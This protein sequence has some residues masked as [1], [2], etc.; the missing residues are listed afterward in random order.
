MPDEL[1]WLRYVAWGAGG[2]GACCLA[3]LYPTPLREL[4]A[5]IIR[6]FVHPADVVDQSLASAW[7][8]ARSWVTTFSARVL[9]Q[10]EGNTFTNAIHGIIFTAVTLSLWATDLFIIGATIAVIG[11]GSSQVDL[12]AESNWII[13][14][15]ILMTGIFW[16]SILTTC[17]GI[18]PFGP[19]ARFA[20]KPFWRNPLV[21]LA[22]VCLALTAAIPMILGDLRVDLLNE[23]SKLQAQQSVAT[24]AASNQMP[25][26]TTDLSG[27]VRILSNLIPAL[28]L[29]TVVISLIGFKM[30]FGYLGLLLLNLVVLMLAPLRLCSWII[31]IFGNVIYG[32]LYR[33]LDLLIEIGN[34]ILRLFGR[35]GPYV[36]AQ[37][38]Q[39]QIAGGTPGGQ[40]GP[41]AHP[42][43]G[44]PAPESGQ[45]SS[46]TGQPAQPQSSSLATNSSEAQSSVWAEERAAASRANPG[47]ATTEVPQGS[48]ER[49]FTPFAVANGYQHTANVTE[50]GSTLESSISQQNARPGEI[51][52][53]TAGQINESTASMGQAA[54]TKDSATNR[55]A[56][57]QSHES[58]AQVE[59]SVPEAGFNPFSARR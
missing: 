37:N 58:P 24:P 11:L 16:G 7:A 34:S 40:F 29:V 38:P 23:V 19:F 44:I 45:P 57:S 12:P 27:R 41:Q 33:F 14:S 54:F 42:P 2:V 50:S 18:Y 17:A 51:F 5:A 20:E 21:W 36:A 46:S 47:F 30:V 6:F 26:A 59:V 3:A 4:L 56:D 22:F 9:N 49:G 48:P 8:S 10:E 1:S 43:E 32:L 15:G 25:A 35:R 39:E 55:P 31:V 52:Q 28:S 13:A 53:S